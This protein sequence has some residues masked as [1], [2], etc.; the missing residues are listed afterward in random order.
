MPLHSDSAIAT[1]GLLPATAPV[2]APAATMT[3]ASATAPEARRK[4]KTTRRVGYA[5]DQAEGP[6]AEG[7]ASGSSSVAS[8]PLANAAAP[9][10][11][12]HQ[13]EPPTAQP[14]PSTTASAAA[15]ALSVP[16][17][18]AATATPTPAA[19]AGH[20]ETSA[21]SSNS[22]T[23][24]RN[25]PP[26]QPLSQPAAPTTAPAARQSGSPTS[27]SAAVPASVQ[28][29]AAQLASL[30]LPDAVAVASMAAPAMSLQASGQKH[31]TLPAALTSETL[32]QVHLHCYA[33]CN[34]TMIVSLY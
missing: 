14:L 17:T 29:V 26:E 19:T 16:A 28:P 25:L 9:L 27:R 31:L 23:L 32:L 24:S 4:K 10:T 3:G 8:I 22:T 18:S 5:R 33:A 2:R 7:S 1:S 30:S 11:P 20:D 12:G 6:A 21:A 34:I 13:A 15:T